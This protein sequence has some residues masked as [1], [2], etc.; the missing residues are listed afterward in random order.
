MPV[1][2]GARLRDIEEEVAPALPAVLAL[3]AV[4][5]TFVLDTPLRLSL[6]IDIQSVHK[7][8]R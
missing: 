7:C 2:G 3:E 6:A 8:V 1:G 4:T 5:D